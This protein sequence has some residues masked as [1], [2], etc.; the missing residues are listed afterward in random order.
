MPDNPGYFE[1]CSREIR[2]L[3]QDGSGLVKKERNLILLGLTVICPCFPSRM[4]EKDTV[5]K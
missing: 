2:D 4:S 5:G 1:S 3:N